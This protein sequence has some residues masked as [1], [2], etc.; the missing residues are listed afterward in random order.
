MSKVSDHY[1]FNA[2]KQIINSL[3]VT[4]CKYCKF[5]K[6]HKNGKEVCEYHETILAPG[7]YCG[8][9]YMK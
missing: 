2:D 6:L 4:S 5:Y 1:L 8:N 7:D 9:P 3:R